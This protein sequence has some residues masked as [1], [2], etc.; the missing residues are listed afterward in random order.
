MPKKKSLVAKLMDLI[1]ENG[2]DVVEGAVKIVREVTKAHERKG[3]GKIVAK[4]PTKMK[5]APKVEAPV[6]L[7]GEGQ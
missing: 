1:T 5:A 7:E 6:S 2:L 4:S 3:P